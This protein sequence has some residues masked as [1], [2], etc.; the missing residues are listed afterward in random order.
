MK[1]IT[2]DPLTSILRID[3]GEDIL[4]EIRRYCEEE[5]ISA[6]TFNGIGAASEVTL[7]W[8]DLT[9]KVYEDKTIEGQW[10]IASLT[11]NVSRKNEKTFVH[12]HGVFSD[13]SM[14]PQAGHVKK[15]IV[16]A[17]CEVALTVIEGNMERQC[18]ERTGL[19]LLR[20]RSARRA[21]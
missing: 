15:L 8:Y 11:G 17:T 13:Q 18:D 2:R 7:S 5:E 6:A 16:S 9:R 3:E 1:I 10:E 4:E 14:I 20:E 21:G 19:F 12:A